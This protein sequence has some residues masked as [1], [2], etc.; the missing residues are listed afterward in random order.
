MASSAVSKDSTSS[1]AHVVKPGHLPVTEFTSDRPASN[2]PFGDDLT[3]PLPV[4]SL[5]YL[6]PTENPWA[7]G[8]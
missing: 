5:V 2:S 7:E 4:S 1:R 8:H 3:F 6:H